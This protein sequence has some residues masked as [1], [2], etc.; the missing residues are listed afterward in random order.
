MKW[1][2]YFFLVN[3]PP[4]SK[5]KKIKTPFQGEFFLISKRGPFGPITEIL[6]FSRIYFFSDV[7]IFFQNLV[8]FLYRKFCLNSPTQAYNI[9]GPNLWLFIL[10]M[11]QKRKLQPPC[12]L[13]QSGILDR[14]AIWDDH[15]QMGIFRCFFVFW[16]FQ[17]SPESTIT[18]A[19]S[20]I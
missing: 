9:Y 1:R 10:F 20:Y 11:A 13:L 12:P 18:W 6:R 3:T 8:H 16:F 19:V 2:F 5:P 15:F 14:L 4:L 7:Y 17:V